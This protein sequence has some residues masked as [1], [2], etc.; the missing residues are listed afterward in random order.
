MILTSLTKPNLVLLAEELGIT[1]QKSMRKPEIIDA[2]SKC[3]A[4]DDEVEECWKA[5]S[6][7]LKE[8]EV[9]LKLK[10]MQLQSLERNDSFDMRGYM[11]PFKAGSDITLY[12]V[13]FERTC[14]RAALGKETW[15]QRLL[16]LLPNEA[17]EIIARMAVEDAR[18]YE[19]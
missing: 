9:E 8:R 19:K 3:G 10:E 13:N 16:T 4:D 2:I 11:Q 1:V 17:T 14:S 7:Q 6:M 12:L 18:D 15:S 5:V